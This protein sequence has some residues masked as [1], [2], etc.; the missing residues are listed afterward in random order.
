MDQLEGKVCV[1]TGGASGIGL[2]LATRFR[3]AGMRV[4]LA[5]LEEDALDA[6]VAGLGGPGEVLGVACD[7]SAATSVEALRRTVI[8]RFGAAHVVC[9]NA[10]V[11]ATGPLLATSPE[12]W[13]W[14]LGVNVMGVVHGV[15][16]FGPLLVDQG[17]GHLVCMASAAG[18]M[19]MRGLGAYGATKHAVVGLAATLRDE[20]AGTG[21]GVSLV[22]PGVVRTGIFR[23]ERNRPAALAGPSHLE[24]GLD[25]AYLAMAQQALGPDVVADAVHDAVRSGRFLV[26]PN[27]EVSPGVLA[28]L[29]ELRAA[30]RG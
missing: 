23:S 5:D 24:G 13:R 1:V 9:L 25:P 28:W 20:L 17:E 29:D 15:G 18:L 27:P 7:V 12:S 4:V 14:M 21:V 6:A 16:A 22:C 10:G 30:F 3:A 19:T 2:A 26:F 8:E 11:A